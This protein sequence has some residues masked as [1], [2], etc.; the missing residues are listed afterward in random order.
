MRGCKLEKISRGNY[1]LQSLVYSFDHFNYHKF[2][3]GGLAVF[4]GYHFGNEVNMKLAEKNEFA[5]YFR[6]LSAQLI[7]CMCDQNL[8]NATK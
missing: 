3:S 4:K 5:S 6:V 7:S 8:R 2:V 1:L